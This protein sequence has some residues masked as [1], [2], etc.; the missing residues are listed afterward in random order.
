MPH[1]IAFVQC[2]LALGAFALAIRMDSA[3]Y[4]SGHKWRRRQNESNYALRREHRRWL[5]H[6]RC[7]GPN[8]PPGSRVRQCRLCP[9]RRNF[10]QLRFPG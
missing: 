8:Q 6:V 7:L 9:K 1:I 2:L 4:E 5:A 3:L 10:W